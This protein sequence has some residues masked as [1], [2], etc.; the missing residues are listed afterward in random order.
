MWKLI[1][2]NLGL[3]TVKKSGLILGHMQDVFLQIPC[4]GWLLIS[5]KGKKVIVDTGP[6]DDEGWGTKYH[7]PLKKS[8]DQRLEVALLKHNID[9]NEIDLSIL[10]HLHWDHAYGALKLPNT[11][12]IIQRT[13]LQ[14][15]IDPFPPDWKHYEKNIAGKD[16][17]FLKFYKQIETVN[18]DCEIDKGLKV[19][20]L[21]GHSPGSQG[22]LVATAEGEFLLAGDLI[23]IMEAWNN[24]PKLPPGIFYSLEDCYSSFDKLNNLIIK[25]N[26]TILPGHDSQVFN[27]V[28]E[29][30]T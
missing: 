29:K 5:K 11:K 28:V 12:L 15:A 7:N 18:G 1:P 2:L 25:S 9:P 17:F 24:D 27:D 8:N 26:V 13:E 4:I 10:T 30:S 22:V 23:N 3:L 14:Y 19:V 20:H 16:P 21:P 6:C